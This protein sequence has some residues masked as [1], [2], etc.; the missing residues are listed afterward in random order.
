MTTR[1]WTNAVCTSIAVAL[2]VTMIPTT[3]S[4]GPSN[5]GCVN[6]NLNQHRQASGCVNADDAFEHLQAFQAIA[7]ANGGTRASGT[8]G[9]DQSADYV[10][11]LLE[12]AGFI[13]ERQV[14]DFTTLHRDLQ[15]ARRSTASTGRDRRPM[16]FSGSG[17]ITAATSSRSTSTSDSATRSTSGCEAADFDGLDF[18]GPQRHRADPARRLRLL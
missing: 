11:G 4:A 1:R 15:L 12:D 2:I 13:V 18:F 14:F 7:D 3:A 6:R 10:A 9:Y 17:A 8:P 5:S 16:S